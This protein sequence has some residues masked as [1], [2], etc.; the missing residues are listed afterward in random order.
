M[1]R[2]FEETARKAPSG[3]DGRALLWT[4]ESLDEDHELEQFFAGIPGFCSSKVV[5]DPRSSLDCLRSRTVGSSLK[6]FFERT[7]SPNLVSETI[8]IRR[9]VICVKAIDA[10]HLS[11][12]ARTILYRYFEGRLALLQSVELGHSLISQSNNDDQ[13]TT[14]FPQCIIACVTSNVPQRNDHWFS[15][16][17]HHLAISGQI[18]RAY[19]DHGESVLIADLIHFTRHFVRNFLKA[20][21]EE[22]PLSYVLRVLRSNFNVQ[23]TLPSLQQDFCSLWNE[24][25][26]QNRDGDHRF[27]SMI[28]LEIHPT[29][30]ALNQ[31][32]TL[33]DAFKSCSIPSH[34]IDA[35]SNLNEVVGDK[36]PETARTPIVTSPAL[37]HHDTI[38]SVI[39]LVTTSNLDH[40]IPH[41][42][43]NRSRNGVL[44]DITLVTSSLHLAA[45]E[46]DRISDGNATDP[47]QRTTDPSAIPSMVDTGSCST[48]CHGVA[49]RPAKNMTTATPSFVPDVVPSPGPIPLL[50]VSPVPAAP[51]ISADPAVNQSGEPPED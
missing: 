20:N 48:S 9:L 40:T 31:G 32:S 42:A 33:Y 47:I 10:A 46:V 37:H 4:Y 44:D 30:V 38:P 16:T 13:M 22:F 41:L 49:S 8:K 1:E 45:L 50:T 51:H 29:H 28:L 2:E 11:R 7:L 5:G 26:L 21:W 23:N 24:V 39:P 3:I 18:L 19:L 43:D 17:M 27:L 34:L 6:E 15:L 36:R 14:L 12:A 35:P 25:A